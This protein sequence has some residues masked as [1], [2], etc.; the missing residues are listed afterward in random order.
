MKSVKTTNRFYTQQRLWW[1]SR[2]YNIN[3]ID[4]KYA[5]KQTVDCSSMIIICTRSINK[6]V[7]LNR[8]NTPRGFDRANV[9]VS[10]ADFTI[11]WGEKYTTA[12]TT[13]RR[14]HYHVCMRRIRNN[15]T[16]AATDATFWENR[17]A[18]PLTS[19]G[20]STR[21]AWSR[22]LRRRRRRRNT[23]ETIGFSRAVCVHGIGRNVSTITID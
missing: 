8:F 23:I 16:S 9:I 21:T 14:C 10:S 15:N 1:K 4:M 6:Y 22:V 3:T 7:S 12:T 17:E 20:V 11:S 2:S 13:N 18:R 19:R 5:N